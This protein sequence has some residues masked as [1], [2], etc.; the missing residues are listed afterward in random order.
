M[1]QDEIIS[2][3]PE[4]EGFTE[5]KSLEK[6]LTSTLHSSKTNLP[7]GSTYSN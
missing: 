2:I 5:S 4:T 1:M 3:K 7:T 6:N